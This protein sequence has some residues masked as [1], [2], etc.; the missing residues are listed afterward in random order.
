MFI[1]RGQMSD[2][3]LC[4]AV[5][6]ALAARGFGF[7]PGYYATQAGSQYE[8][9]CALGREILADLPEEF[10][11]DR[12]QELEPDLWSRLPLIVGLGFR[13][14]SVFQSLLPPGSA[15]ERQAAV[16]GGIFNLVI[17]LVD[18]SVDER[19]AGESTFRK[20]N[21]ATMRAIFA[22][23]DKAQVQLHA[24][25]I[26]SHNLQEQF[27]L[28]LIARCCSR[29][30]ALL[31]TTGNVQAWSDLGNVTLALLQAESQMSSSQW[32]SYEDARALLPQMETKSSLPS[33]ACLHI[34]CLAHTPPA[35]ILDAELRS[36]AAHM[37]RVF[38]LVDDLVDIL[39][40]LRSGT[41]NAVLLRLAKRSALQKRPYVSDTDIYYEADA[42]AEELATM[43]GVGP[44]SSVS[45]NQNVLEFERLLIAGWTAWKEPG[46]STHDDVLADGPTHSSSRALRYLLDQHEDAYREATHHLHFPRL[47]D[48]CV[49]YETRPSILSHRAVILDALID[50]AD[51]GLAV[52]RA[53]LAKDTMAILQCKH[54]DLRGGWSY[55]QEAPELPPD[56]DDL[57]Q[58]LQVLMHF[59][60]QDLASICDEAI[61]MVLDGAAD[62]G[63]FDTW[64][65]DLG[66]VSFADQ[67]TRDY[68]PIMGG[69]GVHVEVVSNLL[70]GLLLYNPGRYRDVLH[71]AVGYLEGEQCDDGSWSSKWYTGPY[72]GTW[73]VLSVL[74]RVAPASKSL[75]KSKRFLLANQQ[76]NGGWGEDDT[77][78]LSTAL[79][80]LA[81]ST[82]ER[83]SVEDAIENG[84]N[85]LARTQ[86]QDGSWHSCPWICFPTTDGM[87]IHGSA[88]ATTAFCLKAMLANCQT[89]TLDYAAYASKETR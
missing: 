14:T 70:Y 30:A 19:G 42:C 89:S 76:E 54:P 50:A 32:K 47:V 80:L 71:R 38:W 44:N 52:P 33:L 7:D 45:L 27:L 74:S 51:S 88:S 68:L 35:G 78:P 46:S 24:M 53:V 65:M 79:A 57:G 61:R 36:A 43:T 86:Q 81:L 10:G 22:N 60:G 9:G 37:G 87:V 55:I 64:I 1:Y 84:I 77:D 83:Q 48:G 25:A 3:H 73:R 11:F 4:A 18:H 8:L 59:G 62:N 66:G 21:E 85:Y 2:S 63:G 39:K 58:V 49:R 41:P 56:A 69:S 31:R 15:L 5:R 40:D 34:A 82:G 75:A 12:L 67:W 26:A 13:Q 29:G 6:V 16:L 20:L 17:T 72:Y 23:P 28:S